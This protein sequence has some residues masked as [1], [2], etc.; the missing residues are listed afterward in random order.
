MD[1]CACLLRIPIWTKAP[2]I[3]IILYLELDLVIGR[4]TDKEFKV[5]DFLMIEILSARKIT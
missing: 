3:E 1:Y 5:G 2:P 4:V